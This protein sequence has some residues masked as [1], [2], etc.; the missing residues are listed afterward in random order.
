MAGDTGLD[1]MKAYIGVTAAVG[2]SYGGA[3]IWSLWRSRS[4]S[5]VVAL[6]RWEEEG[7]KSEMRQGH[8]DR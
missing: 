5:D 4:V 6:P 2:L 8:G 3:P 7:E 1:R